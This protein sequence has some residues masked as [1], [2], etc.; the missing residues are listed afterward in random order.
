[1]SQGLWKITSNDT[2]P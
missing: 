1:L 2:P